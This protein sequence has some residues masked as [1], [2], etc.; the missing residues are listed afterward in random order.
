[1]SGLKTVGA[2]LAAAF[3]VDAIIDVTRRAFDFADAIVDL[4]DRTGASTRAI[5]EFRYA[6][7]MSGSSVESADAA[8]E[9]FSKSMGQA[10]SGNKLMA[11]GLKNL[12]VTSTDVDT[13]LRQFITGVSALPTEAEKMAAATKYMGKSAG[14]LV[15]TLGSGEAAFDTMTKKAQQLGI[16][17]GDDLLRNAGQV[18]DKMDTLKMIIDAEMASAIVKN[19]DSIAYLAQQ[20]INLAVAAGKAFSAMTNKGNFN[21]LDHPNLAA[22]PRAIMG[23]TREQQERGARGMLMGNEDGR[24]G[25]F[26]RNADEMNA[27]TQS[28]KRD[29][30]SVG[31]YSFLKNQNQDILSA[32]RAA[33]APATGG[34]PRGTIDAGGGGP[35]PA[36]PAKSSG[37]SAAEIAAEQEANFNKQFTRST[38][39][40]LRLEGE[41]TNDP[42]ERYD[43]EIEMLKHRRDENRY[44]IANDKK[45]NDA[46]KAQLTALENDSEAIEANLIYRDREEELA[47][48]ALD[49]RQAQLG[50]ESDILRGA[51]S[52]MRTAAARRVAGLKLVDIQYEQER[53]ALDAVIASKRST[54]AEK[55]IA[56]AR[57]NIL[58]TLKGQA[59]TQVKQQT[60]GPME[61]YF[62]QMPK[63]IDEMNEALERVEVEGLSGLTNGIVDAITGVGSLGDAFKNMSKTVIDGLLKIAIQ[64]AIIKPLGSS[65]F[66]GGDSGGGGGLLGNILKGV[67]TKVATPGARANGGMTQPGTYLTGERGPELVNIGANAN[68]TTNAALNRS[69]QR[70]GS[71]GVSVTIQSITSNDPAMVKAMVYE[72]IAQ[73]SP[74]L[75]KQAT[76]ATM[77]R[78][79]RRQL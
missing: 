1:M 59:Q 14:D 24:R 29:K 8:V 27:I 54:D 19:A 41:Q 18:N 3:T 63:S 72:G 49:V 69:M 12:G 34:R 21:I 43:L 32:Q 44:Q 75:T 67:L 2:S 57:L 9:K 61:A 37:K 55:Q 76:D 38:D 40:K 22:V 5:Q 66:G 46:Q 70:G 7:Q 42:S 10:E 23:Q 47:K 58:A 64:Q 13:A 16:V 15:V 20:F 51:E 48:Q 4:A 60:M 36:K 39:D 65:L 33:N 6:A 73:A 50:N 17:M 28:G 56:Q 11:A 26:K 74:M 62:D 53:I 52:E 79:Q 35:K 78:L 30:Q 31:R 77:V 68:V 71:G 25:M 45:L